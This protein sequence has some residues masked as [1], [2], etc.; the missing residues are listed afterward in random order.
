MSCMLY[1]HM[2]GS[3]C[4]WPNTPGTQSLVVSPALPC[5]LCL[6]VAGEEKVGYRKRS[7]REE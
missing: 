7:K 1:D 2:Q 5:P 4:Q 6:Q 3:L